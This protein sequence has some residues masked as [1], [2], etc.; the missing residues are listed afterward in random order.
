M[1]MQNMEV[2]LDAEIEGNV[3]LYQYSATARVSSLGAPA[4]RFASRFKLEQASTFS[5][6]MTRAIQSN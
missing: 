3:S 1:L 6:P 2:D 4:R 5:A